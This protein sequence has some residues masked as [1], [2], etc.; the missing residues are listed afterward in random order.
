[1]WWEAYFTTW[2]NNENFCPSISCFK[3]KTGISFFQS[4]TSRRDREFHFPILVFETRSSFCWLST[5]IANFPVFGV[6]R[7]LLYLCTATLSTEVSYEFSC[8]AICLWFVLCDGILSLNHSCE[9][10]LRE[11]AYPLPNTEQQIHRKGFLIP[12]FVFRFVKKEEG[13][14]KAR[15]YF[16][17]KPGK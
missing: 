8:L 7:L 4:R 2:E 15:A 1:M 14:A 17:C 3:V 10:I 16:R 5:K 11:F 13:I 6:V 9:W 12:V